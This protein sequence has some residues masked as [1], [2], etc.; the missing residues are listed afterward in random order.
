M[1]HIDRHIKLSLMLGLSG[2]S[3]TSSAEVEAMSR[4]GFIIKNEQQIEAPA[5]DVWHALTQQVDAWW[6]KDH[7]WWE[8][9][10]T[11]DAV[12]GGCFCE[13]AGNNSAQ[14]M[15][16]TYVDTNTLLRMTGGLG[17][18]QG[19]GLNGA[20]TWQFTEQSSH[21]TVTLTYRVHGFYPDG[22]ERLAPVVDKVQAMQLLELKNY[23]SAGATD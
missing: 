1:I 6:P 16:I 19:L 12:A 2:I 5:T 7:S 22:F 20:L 8:G 18:L 9:K 23:V 10:L 14:H 4:Q 11:I 13:T 15:R 17:P 21:T 3:Y